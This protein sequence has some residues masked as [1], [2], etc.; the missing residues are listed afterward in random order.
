[1]GTSN[2]QVDKEIIAEPYCNQYCMVF[3]LRAGRV[4]NGAQGKAAV[5]TGGVAQ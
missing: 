3:T 4:R 5:V 2:R 1:V